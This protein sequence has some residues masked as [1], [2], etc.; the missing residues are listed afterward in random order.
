MWVKALVECAVVNL[1]EYALVLHYR[2]RWLLSHRFPRE[3][4]VAQLVGGIRK[5]AFNVG[6]EDRCALGIVGRDDE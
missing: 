1:V 5:F 3:L 2:E 6:D 4:H